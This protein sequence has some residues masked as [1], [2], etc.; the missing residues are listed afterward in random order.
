MLFV[1]VI[2]A[3][4]LLTP[5]ITG[6]VGQVTHTSYLTNY[7][8]ASVVN[9]TPQYI[10]GYKSISD[11]IVINATN[12]FPIAAANYTIE[13]NVVYNGGLAIKIT[14]TGAQPYYTSAWKISG[15]AQPDTYASDS[16][17]RAVVNLI[18]IFA[19][20]ALIGFV[21]YYVYKEGSEFIGK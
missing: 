3:L 6:P 17:T 21:I 5:G 20:L 13:N 1:G 2:V 18:I 4:T 11:A 19:A 10:T 9:G 7:S 14:P 12:S 16:G 8:L 15:L